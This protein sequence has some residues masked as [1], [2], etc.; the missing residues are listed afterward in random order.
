MVSDIGFRVG[1]SKGPKQWDLFGGSWV[2]V[3][4]VITRISMVTIVITYTKGLVAPH[5]LLLSLHESAQVPTE[6]HRTHLIK[7]ENTQLEAKSLPEAS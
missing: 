2:V 1:A 4:R 5:R 7:T 6:H 3:S